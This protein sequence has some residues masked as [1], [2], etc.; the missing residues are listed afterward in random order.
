MAPQIMT[1]HTRLEK[2]KLNSFETAFPLTSGRSKLASTRAQ[3]GLG[4]QCHLLH[5]WWE[6]QLVKRSG[7]KLGNAS[8]NEQQDL[9]ASRNSASSYFYT[10]C[11]AAEAKSEN[12]LHD[13]YYHTINKLRHVEQQNNTDR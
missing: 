11:D 7:G 4:I 6:R 3:E 9:G 2:R 10:C 5:S 1:S 13:L 12:C 8:A